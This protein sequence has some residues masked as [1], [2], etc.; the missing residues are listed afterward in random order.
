[1]MSKIPSWLK[2]D[3]FVDYHSIIGGPITK[4]GLKV[5]YIGKM[6]SSSK[7]D[8]V[9]VDGISGCVAVKALTLHKS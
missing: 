2:V 3:Q 8:V 4:Y 7:E 5:V 1:M 9:W 6:N